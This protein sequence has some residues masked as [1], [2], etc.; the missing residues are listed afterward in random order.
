[1]IEWLQS[2]QGGA[3]TFVGAM[4]GSLIGFLA[5]VAGALFNSW[6]NRKRDDNLRNI[7]T[8]AIAAAL[9]AE[10]AGIEGTLTHNAE[11][12]KNKP[13]SQDES[14][15]IPDLAHSVRMF[16]ALSEKLGLFGDPEIITKVVGAYIVVDQYCENLLMAGGQLGAGMPEHR[17]IILMPYQRAEFVS[18]L[19]LRLPTQIKEAMNLLNRFLH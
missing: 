10:L 18:N 7:E 4:T 17:R 11:S 1:M 16:P 9:R 8:R 15:F 6:L 14:F 19:S 5:L 13:P 12:L 2:L 3:A